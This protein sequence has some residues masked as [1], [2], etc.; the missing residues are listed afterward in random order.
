M[1]IFIRGKTKCKIC[2][3]L[4]EDT[5]ERFY[6]SSFLATTHPLWRYSDA[7]MHASCYMGWD[8]RAEFASEYCESTRGWYASHPDY[9]LLMETSNVLVAYNS[10]HVA[11]MILLKLI[12]VLVDVGLDDLGAWLSHPAAGQRFV[13]A[14]LDR[15]RVDLDLIGG[16]EHVLDL[17]RSVG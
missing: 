7:T 5:D 10:R 3:R 4:I 2:D 15:V 17:L 16:K 13:Q 11:V 12:A 8:R 14:E 6:T 9:S 1:A